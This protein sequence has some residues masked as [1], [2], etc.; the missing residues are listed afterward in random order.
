M[1]R[2]P[3]GKK[4]WFDEG[5]ETNDRALSYFACP[6]AATKTFNEVEKNEMSADCSID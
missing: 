2:S 6:P 5:Q 3:S 4:P 1:R